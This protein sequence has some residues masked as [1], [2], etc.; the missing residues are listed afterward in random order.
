MMIGK[1]KI[2]ETLDSLGVEYTVTEHAPMY[3]MED[4]DA[5][6]ITAKGEVPKNLFLRDAKG[7]N[8]Y[9]V[10]LQKDKKA[11][12]SAIAA[13]L[14]STKLSFASPERL[15]KYLGL[16]KGAVTPLGVFHDEA[17]AVVVA[18]DKDFTDD[19]LI[20]VHPCVNTATVWMKFGTL[21]RL[22]REHGNELVR[23]SI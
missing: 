23:I 13:Q 17:R 5:A 20:G 2:L 21:C 1:E 7:K 14:D 6:G 9:L 8:H 16:E 10:V 11:D 12:L 22:V 4:M 15:E 3:T 18:F 19:T